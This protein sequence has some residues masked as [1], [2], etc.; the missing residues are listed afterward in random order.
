MIGE[1]SVGKIDY[2]VVTY[3]QFVD[4]DDCIMDIWENIFIG[5]IINLSFQG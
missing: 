1:T 4:F 2:K 3:H 5:G